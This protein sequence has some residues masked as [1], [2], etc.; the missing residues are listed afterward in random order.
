MTVPPVIIAAVALR[1][2]PLLLWPDSPCTRDDCTYLTLAHGLV[3]G[4]GM[5]G[6]HGW[7]WAPGYP[8]FLAFHE[9]W[10]GDANAARWTQ[11]L[12]SG[13]SVPLVAALAKPFGSRPAQ[14]A[15]WLQAVSPTQV[16]FSVNLWSEGIYTTLLLGSLVAMQH[17][18]KGSAWWAAAS[19]ALAGACILFR[20]MAIGILPAIAMAFDRKRLAVALLACAVV[21]VPYSLS[22]SARFGGPVLADR[23]LGQMMWLGNNTFAPVTFDWENGAITEERYRFATAGGRGHCAFENDPLR[24]DRCE[25]EAGADWI[26]GHP[27]AFI[28]RIPVR[29]AQLLNPHS[30]LTRHLRLA[31]WKGMPHWLDELLIVVTVVVSSISI[32][33]GIIGWT[34][35]GYGAFAR[36]SAAL[37]VWH[38]LVISVLAGLTRYRV[39]LE[40]IG[41][42]WFATLFSERALPP[43][44]RIRRWVGGVIVVMAAAEMLWFLPS[45]WPTW[46]VW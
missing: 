16:F 1:I 3:E 30:F 37:V 17:S 40:P 5:V 32:L 43:S 13:A 44:S 7:L 9:R 26:V 4:K 41:C 24:Q 39:P 23:T 29:L 34:R 33:G 31:Y 2:L 12:I 45:A 15:A 35:H 25:V 20:G 18:V 19:G 46:R 21:V 36:S 42:V 11:A 38:V 6:T 10:F 28:E 14:V 22:A 27:A 8:Y